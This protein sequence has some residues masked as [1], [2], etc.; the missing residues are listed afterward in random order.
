M[1]LLLWIVMIAIPSTLDEMVKVWLMELLKRVM[2]TFIPTLDLA[3][4][5]SIM[6]RF[7][8]PEKI[9][10]R[11]CDD[12]WKEV[13]LTNQDGCRPSRMLLGGLRIEGM[14]I[15]SSWVVC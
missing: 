6:R 2:N 13:E 15:G 7:V 8:W 12:V 10:G 11:A 5:K 14:H 4:V 3:G 1:E 9:S